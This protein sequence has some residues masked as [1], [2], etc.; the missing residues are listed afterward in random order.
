MK[1]LK[2]IQLLFFLLTSI[3]C[4]YFNHFGFSNNSKTDVYIDLNPYRA[5][6]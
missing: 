1:S 4:D 6:L 2:F 3:A 5:L